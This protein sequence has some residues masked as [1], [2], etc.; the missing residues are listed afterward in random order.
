MGRSLPG[1]DEDDQ[2]VLRYRKTNLDI[3]EPVDLPHIGA[4]VE[5]TVC[6]RGAKILG[7]VQIRYHEVRH[8]V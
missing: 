8:S 2:L 1:F 7:F 3:P 5:Q 4:E 6:D